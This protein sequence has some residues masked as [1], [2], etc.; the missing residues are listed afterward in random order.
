MCV[1]LL[2]AVGCN[3][4]NSKKVENQHNFDAIHLND[5]AA[6]MLMQSVDSTK[7]SY[8]IIG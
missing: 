3:S 6:L 1:S 4:E 2:F 8:T 5:S 7:N